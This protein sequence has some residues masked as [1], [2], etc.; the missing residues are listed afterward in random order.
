[1]A[2]YV[3]SL[4]PYAIQFGSSFG[5]RWYGLSYLAGFVVGYYVFLWLARRGR[6]PLRPELVGDFIFSVALG[7]IIGGRLGYCLFYDQSLLIKFSGIFPFWGLFEV[8]HG[9]MASHGGIVGIITACYLF[10]RKHQLPALRLLDL[11]ALAGGIGIFFGR[12]ANFINGELVGRPC[13]PDLPWAVKFPQDIFLWPFEAPQRLY[14]LAPVVA[15]LGIPETTWRTAIEHS[16]GGPL[17][18]ATLSRIVSSIQ[19]GNDSLTLALAPFL[20]PRHP[21]QLYEALLEGAFLFIA[22]LWLWRKPRQPGVITGS[23]LVLY[24][25]VRIIGEQFRMPDPG[26]GFQLFG[27]TRGQW[28]SIAMLLV[29]SA[30]LCFWAGRQK[31]HGKARSM[32]D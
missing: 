22:M 3:D 24:S 21:S 15:K 7:T 32:V 14:D 23:F 25:I 13:S 17:V 4:N 26:I 5:I 6:T 10:A 27:L 11:A 31:H 30:L 29:S 16:P 8:H 2:P 20:T 12:I 9:G 19:A 1:M 28:L 18:E